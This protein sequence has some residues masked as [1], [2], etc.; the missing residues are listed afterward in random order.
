[1]T[2][3]VSLKK[4]A[5]DRRAEKDAMG[6]RDVVSVPAENEGV[7][8]NLDHHHLMNMGVGGGMK[9]GHKVSFNGTGT[10]ERS[11]SRSTPEGERHSATLRLDR[12]G[13][14]HEGDEAEEERGEIKTEIMSAHDKAEQ[15]RVDREAKAKSGKSGAKV[16]EG[17]RV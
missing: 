14:E 2:K 11:E 3:M 10:V 4:S 17:D 13:I 1:M 16:K 8:V 12:G 6:S 15:G 7:T 5:A 9:S